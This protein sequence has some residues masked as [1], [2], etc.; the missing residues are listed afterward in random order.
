MTVTRPIERML[1]GMDRI[2]TGIYWALRSALVIAMMSLF[3]HFP[4]YGYLIDHL[5][6]RSDLPEWNN[7][8]AQ[9][10]Q[11]FTPQEHSPETHRAKTAFRLTVPV[12]AKVLRLDIVGLMALSTFIGVL[13]LYL[14]LLLAERF[15]NDKR[16]AFL[17]TLCL[18]MIYAGSAAFFD[19]WGF[20][21]AFGYF[22]LLL[23]LYARRQWYIV[24]LAVFLA[25]FTDERALIASS[26][27]FVFHWQEHRR[28]GA[29]NL[30]I[31]ALA[32][33]AAWCLYFLCRWGL[34]AR[35]HF[36]TH[37]DLIGLPSLK[38]NEPLLMWSAWMMFEGGWLLV[39]PMFLIPM[40]RVD[41]RRYIPYAWCALLIFAVGICVMDTTRSVAYGSIILVPALCYATET[42][43]RIRT[44]RIL[45]FA[46]LVSLL[47]PMNFMLGGRELL[48]VDP[49]PIKIIFWALEQ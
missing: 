46:A 22:F 39:L 16:Q 40:F 21:D 13:D 32:C 11:L 42:W 15:T 3:L 2:A 10:D 9:R 12:L 49:L 19:V 30:P 24:F 4:A 28:Q 43:D 44:Q 1:S 7:V 18:A 45:L 27:V 36:Q 41:Q 20:F 14:S 6:G 17:F 31:N 23:A 48:S 5:V 34:S 38:M 26:V 37:T 8:L 47:Q 35:F 33:A 25:S 29:A